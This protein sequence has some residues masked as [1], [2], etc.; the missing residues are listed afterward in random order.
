MYASNISMQSAAGHEH[1]LSPWLKSVQ[2]LLKML[3][4]KKKKNPSKIQVTYETLAY[5]TALV[6]KITEF[7]F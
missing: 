4:K 5:V 3:K 6:Q 2:L 1:L 7:G